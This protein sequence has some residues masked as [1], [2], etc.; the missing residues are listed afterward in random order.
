MKY[1]EYLRVVEEKQEKLFAA[2]DAVWDAAETAFSE[3]TSARVLCDLMAGE[4]F[5]VTRPAFGIQTAFTASYGTGRPVMGYLGEFDALANLDQEAGC[6]EKKACHPGANGHGCGHNM[7]GVAAAAAAMGVK[8]YLEK[9]GKPGTVVFFGCPGEEGGS[10]KAFMAREGAFDDLDFAVTWHPSDTNCVRTG[11]SLANFQVLFKFNGISAHAAGCPEMGRSALDAL[12]LMNVGANFLREHIIQAARL[13]Y[14]ILDAGGYS[15][16]VV[17]NHAE[18]LYLIRA[19]RLGQAKEIYDR[20]VKIAQGAAL[21]TETTME[22]ELIKSCA[23]VV[24]NQ[25]MEKVM[26]EAM[27]DVP[28]PQYTPEEY[29]TAKAF[30]ATVPLPEGASLQGMIDAEMD[31]E[32]RAFLVSKKGSAIHDF[33]VPYSTMHTDVGT[34]GSTDVGDVSWQT[35]TVQMGGATWAPNTPGHSWQVVA[36]GKGSLAHKG[37]VYAGQCMAGTA[38][39]MYEDP[40]LITAAREEL[41]TRLEGETYVPIPKGIYPRA[42]S[43]LTKK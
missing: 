36:Q 37:I 33:V 41:R 2:S 14:A 20:V 26:Y 10:G 6:V 12:E 42:I 40:A 13:H 25:V 23:N 18:V 43:D 9:T 29:E 39:R 4:G 5:T 22:Y 21:M 34:G 19:P 16:N 15:P 8:E 3:E 38:L 30:T 35:P 27:T 1:A 32:A 28:L 24:P 11:S 17:Q 7:L 31:E